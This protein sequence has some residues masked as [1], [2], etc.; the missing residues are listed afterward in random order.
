MALTLGAAAPA[1]KQAPPVAT[2]PTNGAITMTLP[3]AVLIGLRKNRTI[4]TEYL[5]RIADKFALYVAEDTFTPTANLTASVNRS[6]SL[7]T[8]TTSY[9]IGPDIS[10]NLPTGAVLTGGV[11]NLQSNINGQEP[12]AN[13]QISFQIIQ[14]LLRGAGYDIASAPIRL[15]RLA[16]K[17]AKLRMAQTVIDTVTQIIIS[18][19]SLIQTD[20]QMKIAADALKRSRDLLEVNRILIA[21]GRLAA[22]EVVQSE[23][24]IAQQELALS[25]AQ[26]AYDA[27]RIALLTLLA[28]DP[29]AKIQT[30][31]KLV[32]TPV[33]VNEAKALAVAFERQPSYLAQLVTIEVSKI[34]LDVARNQRLWDLSVVAGGGQQASNNN[35]LNSF[36]DTARGH[37]PDYNVGLQVSIP[38][39]NPQLE[40]GE[41]NT[42]IALRQAQLQEQ[43]LHDQVGQ[44]VRDAVRNIAIQG[45]QLDTARRAR[46]LAAQ[47]LD[48]ELVKLQVG[49]SSNFQ[50]VAFQNALQQAETQELTAIISYQNA[51]T[52][53]DQVLG[54]TLDTWKINLNDE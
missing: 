7:G 43:Q 48:I 34:N 32:A 38:L 12:S 8:K 10:W 9:N 3:D 52:T 26:N 30:V 27:A 20:E 35:L 41:V 25:T 28:L 6:R 18:Y 37:R 36:N 15:G 53:L 29:S 2:A 13:S 33:K 49:R 22:V 31:D 44:Q 45:G 54:T 4:K 39:H 51:L 14:P 47:Q 40:Q 11:T 50:V 5:Q 24:S 42:T 23:A 1:R 21:A 46:E 17:S 19:R 16:E